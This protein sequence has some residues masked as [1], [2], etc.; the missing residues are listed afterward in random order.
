MGTYA[1]G[2]F[3]SSA[4]LND[5]G[6]K[7]V[8]YGGDQGEGGVQNSTGKTSVGRLRAETNPL[9]PNNH[10][11]PYSVPAPK[12]TDQGPTM[13]TG[14]TVRDRL[15]VELPNTG[16]CS[17]LINQPRPWGQN[18]EGRN[19]VQIDGHHGFERRG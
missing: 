5:P 16:P 17:V 19:F 14:R 8:S 10:K 12:K 13:A 4:L 3:A 9:P 7:E 15:P 18:T 11:I 1:Q 2:A 6:W